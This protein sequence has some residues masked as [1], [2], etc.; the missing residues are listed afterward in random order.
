VPGCQGLDAAP[1]AWPQQQQQ[2]Q[3]LHAPSTISGSA[4]QCA[5]MDAGLSGW[6]AQDSWLETPQQVLNQSQLQQQ[7]VIAAASA[8]WP[9]ADLQPIVPHSLGEGCH[10]PDNWGEGSYMQGVTTTTASAQQLDTQHPAVSL[11]MPAVQHVPGALDLTQLQCAPLS[12]QQ[13]GLQHATGVHAVQ[14]P[15]GGGLLSLPD[16]SPAASVTLQPPTTGPVQMPPGQAHEQGS[17]Q[18]LL[19]G[20][21]HAAYAPAHLQLQ[22]QD[23]LAQAVSQTGPGGIA[24]QDPQQSAQVAAAPKQLPVSGVCPDTASAVQLSCS[25]GPRAAPRDTTAGAA[26]ASAQAAAA[27][28][29][30]TCLSPELGFWECMAAAETAE[31][32]SSEEI[33]ALL[34]HAFGDFLALE[35]GMCETA[36]GTGCSSAPA[37]PAA[38][39]A[40]PAAG[41]ACASAAG[42]QAL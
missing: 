34:E 13:T 21:A 41:A 25:L 27:A 31:D 11:P 32:F 5:G 18:A 39:C 17:Y 22:L 36:A 24:K 42:R 9:A 1:L 14:V 30:N 15:T 26:S 28:A 35:P 19:H 8:G 12:Q 38:G 20:S 10:M 40:T 37:S 29:S 16:S 2:Q 6:Q 3:P 23:S 7:S 4:V 33:D